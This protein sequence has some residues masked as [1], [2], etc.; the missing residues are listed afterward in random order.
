MLRNGLSFDIE[1]WFQVYNYEGIIPRDTWDQC[2]SRVRPNTERILELLRPRSV[3]ATF[4]VLGWVAERDPDLVRL[5][6]DAGHEVGTHGYYHRRVVDMTPEEFRLD[7]ERSLDVLARAGVTEVLGFRA[8]SFSVVESTRW[9]LEI[10]AQQGLR[11]D[12][13]IFPTGVHPDYGIPDAPL[14]PHSVR[15]DLWEVPLTVIEIAG[16]R[17]PVGGGGYFRLLPYAATSWAMRRV[18][19]QGRPVV[20]YL[21]P[22]EL[23]PGQP[24]VETSRWRTFRQTVNLDKTGKRLERLLE[25]FE[26]CPLQEMIDA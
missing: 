16:R 19:R 12:S 6:R 2:E 25:E 9:S 15:E 17:L 14:D 13:S 7:L 20:V 3:R 24:R 11:Y 1:D 22:W 8:P 21:H 4:F 23:D 26:F 10:L 5:I 18:N